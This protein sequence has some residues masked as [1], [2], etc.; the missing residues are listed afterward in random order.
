MLFA[1]VGKVYP[2]ATRALCRVVGRWH[3]QVVVRRAA[4]SACAGAVRNAGEW[5]QL[6]QVEFK[7]DARGTG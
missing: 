2:P 4:F 6:E 7:S 1:P 5:K 3:W